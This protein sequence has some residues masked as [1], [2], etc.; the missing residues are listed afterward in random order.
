ED[1]D[2]L[3]A[4][5]LVEEPTAARLHEERVPGELEEAAGLHLPG[6]RERRAHLAP[7]PGRR[8]LGD[9]DTVDVAIAGAPRVA[10]D[11]AAAALVEDGELVAQPVDRVAERAPPRLRRIPADAAPAVGPPALDAVRAAPRRALGDLDLVG[12]GMVG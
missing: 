3:D 8:P 11:V 6:G 1:L 10:E 9:E 7:E 4:R 2:R 5:Q 12:G